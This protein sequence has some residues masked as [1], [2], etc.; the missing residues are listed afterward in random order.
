MPATEEVARALEGLRRHPRPK[1]VA[2]LV[3]A[4]NGETDLGRKRGGLMRAA[5]TD[6]PVLAEGPGF[7]SRLTHCGEVDVAVETL[8]GGRDSTELFRRAFS[9]G[10]CQVPHWGYLVKGRMRVR[11]PDHEEVILAGE[12]WYMPPGH[13][14]TTEEDVENIVFTLAGEYE[15]LMVA[16]ARGMGAGH[17]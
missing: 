3:P 6:V 13:I 7:T 15:Q 9:D 14:P 5:P 2:L 4:A 12:V 10:R 11:Y 17:G 1:A 8:A 16:L